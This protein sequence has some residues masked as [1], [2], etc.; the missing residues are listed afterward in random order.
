[1]D[2]RTQRSRPRTQKKSEAKAKDRLP[3]DISSRGQG[4]ECS[5][6]RPRIQGL[7]VLRKKKEKVSKKIFQTTSKK[8]G[9]RAS[10]LQFSA[11]HQAF[12]KKKGLREFPGEVSGVFQGKVKKGHGHDPFLTIQKSP[13][14]E[15]RTGHFRK[16]VG[17]EA[18][19][20]DFKMCP[21]G[22]GR[23]Q[24]LHV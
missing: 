11:K 19:V 13:V 14:I 6:P 20:K 12:S 10:K 4:E 24:R 5:R 22:Q 18:K 17:F 3:E 2:S 15:P 7:S 16:R 23:P 9:L 8:K 1:M 21:G